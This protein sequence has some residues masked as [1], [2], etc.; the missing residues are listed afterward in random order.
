M[1]IT[2]IPGSLS[3]V[4]VEY[5]SRVQQEIFGCECPLFFGIIEHLLTLYSIGTA[6]EHHSLY[7]YQFV[8][9]K[10]IF[11]GFIQ[12]ETPYE[13]SSFALKSLANFFFF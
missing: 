2:P 10:S 13:L 3:T 11:M 12:T 6:V 8:G 5:L 9:T 1:L 4:A 7:Q